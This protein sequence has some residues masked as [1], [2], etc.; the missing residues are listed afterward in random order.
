MG[1]SGTP[2]SRDGWHS[3]SL[4]PGTGGV[5]HGYTPELGSI[6]QA[7]YTTKVEDQAAIARKGLLARFRRSLRRLFW[8]F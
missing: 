3:G 8:E 7:E 5:R 4:N 1:F 2:P 6:A